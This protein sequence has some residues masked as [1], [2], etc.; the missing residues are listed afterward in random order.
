MMRATR[1]FVPCRRQAARDANNANR[2]AV[3][4]ETQCFTRDERGRHVPCFHASRGGGARPSPAK[5]RAT[6]VSGT[7]RQRRQKAEAQQEGYRT[8][9]VSHGST[10]TRRQEGRNEEKA[11]ER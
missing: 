4:P 7:T 8:S 5:E 1:A 11:A 10:T 9:N 2:R 6:V 3:R